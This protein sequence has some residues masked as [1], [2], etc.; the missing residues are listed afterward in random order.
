MSHVLD[1]LHELELDDEE[2][3]REP[4]PKKWKFPRPPR[5]KTWLGRLK[6]DLFQH[7]GVG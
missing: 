2:P 1:A 6:Q 4:K 3:K 7:G 5:A